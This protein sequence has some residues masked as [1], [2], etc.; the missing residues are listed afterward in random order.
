M[1]DQRTELYFPFSTPSEGLGLPAEFSHLR[2][3]EPVAQVTLP[4]GDK[5]WLVTRYDD[6][7]AVLGDPRFSR[8][9]A[10]TPD[11]P[12]M[13][14]TTPGAD[15]I[16][17]MDPPGHTRLRRLVSKAF[18]VRQVERLRPRVHEI[19]EDLLTRLLDAGPP[20]DLISGFTL[21]LP[22]SVIFELLGVPREDG[23]MVHGWTDV[24]FSLTAHSRDEVALARSELVAYMAALIA[25]KRRQP[26]DDLL[27][28]L[29]AARDEADKLSE[30]ELL[31]L[32]CI[33]I[34]VG[35][36]STAGSLASAILVLLCHPNGIGFLSTRPDAI[37]PA[38]EELLRFNPFGLTGSQLRVAVGDT[39]LAGVTIRKGE[40]VIAAIP[41]A[42]HDPATFDQPHHVVLTRAANPHMAFGYGAHHC[43]G[44]PLAR[45]ELQVALGSLARRLPRLELAVPWKEL[46][47][48]T[49][50]AARRLV[51][52]PVTW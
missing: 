9:A 48:K 11:A 27:S 13:G 47:W 10:E 49:G 38:V 18:T 2:Q 24:M 8:A 15:T 28:A 50:P 6:V 5:A 30:E 17:G 23:D 4:T 51:Q 7:R 3:E 42:N 40:A 25:R 35:H 33:L 44:A 14:N 19:V 45:V 32:G 34:A 21:Q 37:T 26:D 22:I 1:S 41:A 12:R 52:L 36:E 43:L 46:A 29:V 39:T 31:S 16:L 20:A